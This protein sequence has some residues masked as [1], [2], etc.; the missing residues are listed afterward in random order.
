MVKNILED[1]RKEQILTATKKLI[2]QR[3]YSNF[4]M[5]DIAEELEMSTGMIYHYFDNKEDLMVLVLKYSFNTIYTKV[6]KADSEFTKYPDRIQ[7]YINSINKSLVEDTEFYSLL[8]NYFGQVAY[9]PDIKNIVAKFLKNNRQFVEQILR[10]GVDGQ[11]IHQ[12]D[13][14]SI[15]ELIVA[16]YMGLVFQYIVDPDAINLEEALEKNKANLFKML[17]I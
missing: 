9:S 14:E 12:D 17:N 8:L 4:S 15:A 11:Y 10:L 3:G 5:K 6:T 16:T 13:V 2:I 1:I 7:A